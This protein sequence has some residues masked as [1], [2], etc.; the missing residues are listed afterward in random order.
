MNL[1]KGIDKSRFRIC[2]VTSKGIYSYFQDTGIDRFVAIEDI[3]IDTWFSS[4]RRFMID[5]RRVASLLKEESPDL[6]FGMMHYPSSLLVFAKKIYK[7]KVKVIV[8]P[9]GTITGISKAF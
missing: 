4:L 7:R 8:S 6:A 1:L 5:I 2:L 3:G 9:R